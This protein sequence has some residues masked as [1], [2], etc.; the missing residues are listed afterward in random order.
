MNADDWDAIKFYVGTVVAG[1]AIAFVVVGV[2]KVASMMT[3]IPM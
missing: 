3:G 1:F 2:I